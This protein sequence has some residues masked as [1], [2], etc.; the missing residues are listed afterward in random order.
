MA[1]HIAGGVQKDLPQ[2]PASSAPPTH[3]KSVHV[4]SLC[5]CSNP[6]NVALECR[7]T[8]GS[9]ALM[10]P[11]YSETPDDGSLYCWMEV[12]PLHAHAPAG[13]AGSKLRSCKCY[14][15]NTCIGMYHALHLWVHA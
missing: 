10:S 7:F 6:L 2:D 13:W 12:R 4:Y 15:T 3:A 1:L 11:A 5:V 14:N 8:L 9:K